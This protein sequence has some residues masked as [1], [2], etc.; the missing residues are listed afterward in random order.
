MYCQI[1]HISLDNEKCDFVECITIV[2]NLNNYN[3]N[4]IIHAL[5]TAISDKKR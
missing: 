3:K 1:A 4:L 5:L 2:Y